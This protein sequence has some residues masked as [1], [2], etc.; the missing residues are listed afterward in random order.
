MN[1]LEFLDTHTIDWIPLNISIGTDG[2]KIQQ[3]PKGLSFKDGIVHFKG[4]DEE[5]L[6]LWQSRVGECSHI[7][8]DTRTVHQLDI[9][10]PDIP[11]DIQELKESTPYFLSSTKKL[12]HFFFKSSSAPKK[13]KQ[14]RNGNEKHEMLTGIWSYCPKDAKLYNGH[15]DIPT[16]SL[17]N[18]QPPKQAYSTAFLKSFIQANIPNHSKTQVKE[19]KDKG[20]I[21]TNGRFCENVGREHR[22]NHVWFQLK[23]D[24]ISMRCCDPEC[25]GFVGKKYHLKKGDE[26]TSEL[27]KRKQEFELYN[28]KVLKPV[29]FIRMAPDGIQILNKQELK[30]IY[31]N[32]P[33]AGDSSF[34]NWW[35]SQEDIKTFERID[36]LP[37]PCVCPKNVYNTWNGFDAER[38]V[39]K[40]MGSPNRF[41]EHLRNLFGKENSQYVLTWLATIIQ[42]P[43]KHTGIC[44][45]VIGSQG[46]GKTTV[47]ENIMMRIIG[48][49]YH[50]ATQ[51]PENSLF[52]KFG[53]MRNQKVLVVLDDFNVG[54]IKL[55]ADP[56]KSF[57]TGERI[58]YEQKGKQSV[59]LLNCSNYVMTTNRYDPVK[60]DSDDRRYAILECK[61]FERKPD[62]FDKLHD[63]I[64]EPEN[65]RAIYEFLCDFD[66]N[67]INLAKDRPASE[68]FNDIKA[69]S[70]DKELLFIAS[71]VGNVNPTATEVVYSG[72]DIYFEYLGWLKTNG[73]TDYKPKNKNAFGMYVKRI[74]GV[75]VD[76]NNGNGSKYIINM[77][78][79]RPFLSKNNL[80]CVDPI[81]EVNFSTDY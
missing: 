65:I 58:N 31:E 21:L 5:T 69:L 13:D 36:M 29:C 51:D 71:K 16:W 37:P 57:I 18:D 70:V 46:I 32:M 6:K 72:K 7:A 67:S 20:Q 60:L 48:L 43:G 23:D 27:Q 40:K 63:Y 11:T 64:E 75:S 3:P 38:I 56:F 41:V 9:D 53:E 78:T 10:D 19:V 68:L 55:N 52:G 45:V 22:S 26:E 24:C 77:S 25:S 35:L 14:F 73:Y 12:P 28:F 59:S 76:R 61:N 79:L 30:I 50:G 81:P 39:T 15:N 42:K 62:Y 33:P 80:G 47:F 34:I 74:P 8:I 17:S 4:I 2:K 44:L 54:S 66:T 49:M 1:I